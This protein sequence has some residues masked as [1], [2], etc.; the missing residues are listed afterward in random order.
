MLQHTPLN[1]Q[2]FGLKTH[3]PYRQC[4]HEAIK[5][6]GL[7]RLIKIHPLSQKMFTWRLQKHYLNPM[8]PCYKYRYT[9][10]ITLASRAILHHL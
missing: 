9:V 2:T 10:T 4:R 6:S 3:N 1:Y 5:K 7:Y 8:R